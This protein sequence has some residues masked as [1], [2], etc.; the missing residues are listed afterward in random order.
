ML[1]H[2]IDI[3]RSLR[4]IIAIWIL[5][6]LLLILPIR[7]HSQNLGQLP[8]DSVELIND[9][10]TLPA[11]ELVK[12]LAGEIVFLIVVMISYL[13]V[14]ARHQHVHHPKHLPHPLN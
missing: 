5:L 4:I 12:L 9:S 1:V 7:T 2:H 3:R 8:P 13:V 14:G 10:P 6:L 11:R